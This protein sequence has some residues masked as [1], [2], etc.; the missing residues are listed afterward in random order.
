MKKLEKEELVLGE[1]SGQYEDNEFKILIK[2][3]GCDCEV[4]CNGK[5]L[6]TVMKVEIVLEASEL[7]TIKIT[8][9]II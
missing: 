7:S 9:A 8:R 4:F 2:P 6:E 3:R 5:R 1:V